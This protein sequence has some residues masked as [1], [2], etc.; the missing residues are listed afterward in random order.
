MVLLFLYTWWLVTL[1]VWSEEFLHLK[2]CF[3]LDPLFS[4]PPVLGAPFLAGTPGVDEFLE[5]D[6]I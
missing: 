4:P 6:D 3:G 2:V 5:G 1:L